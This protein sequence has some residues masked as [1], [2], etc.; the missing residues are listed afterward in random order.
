MRLIEVGKN[1]YKQSNIAYMQ[2]FYGTLPHSLTKRFQ[3]H[4]NQ[5]Y[6]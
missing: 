4:I 2:Y 6:N 3:H 5:Q 1:A